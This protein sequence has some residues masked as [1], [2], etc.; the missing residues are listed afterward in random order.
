MV[1]RMSERMFGFETEYGITGMRGD[2]SMDR[3][4]LVDRLMQVARKH[5]AHL[6]DAR[7]SGMFLT[8]GSRLYI[9]QG[10]HPELCTPECTNPWDAVRYVKAGERIM[11]GIVS[12]MSSETGAEIFC[13]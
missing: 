2:E 4:L 5:L 13:F 12:R 7:T 8:N 9:D 3:G 1:T 6:P 11:D 10:C